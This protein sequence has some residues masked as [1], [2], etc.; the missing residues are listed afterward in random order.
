MEAFTE[1][2]LREGG[3]MNIEIKKG[4]VGFDQMTQTPETDALCEKQRYL[5]TSNE[6][7]KIDALKLARRLER[8]RDELRAEVERWKKRYYDVAD[9][10]CAKNKDCED[11]CRQARETRAEVERIK[12]EKAELLAIIGSSMDDALEAAMKGDE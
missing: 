7:D 1:N 6:E 12:A 5:S 3:Q 9:T 11:L 8:E 10:L 2:S 4:A